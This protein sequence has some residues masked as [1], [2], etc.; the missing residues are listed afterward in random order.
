MN[1][2]TN[3]R[4]LVW[5][6]PDDFMDTDFNPALFQLLLQT[7]NI[8]WIIILPESKSRYAEADFADLNKLE[9]MEIKFLYSSYRQRDPRRLVFYSILYKEINRGKYDLLYFSYG[10]SEPYAIPLFRILNRNKT[11]FAV[12]E[13]NVNDNFRLPMMSNIILNATYPF[14]KYV[15]MFSPSSAAIFGRKYSKAKIFIIP[16]GLK[17]FGAGKIQKT[18][19]EIVFLSFG[20]IN[21]AKNI[22]LLI[23][24]ACNVYDKGFRGF[25]VSINGSCGNW[26][27]YKSK[28]RYPK[29][30]SCDIRKIENTEIADLFSGSH[31]L[32]QPY[33]ST[34]QSGVLKIALNYNVPIIASDLPGFKDEIE[35]GVN[36]FLFATGD[37][38][39][40]E[41][42]LIQ[43]IQSH[44]E[45]YRSL[46]EKM[47]QH[48]AHR[49]SAG[50]LNA[51][52]LDLF[53]KVED[54]EKQKQP[55]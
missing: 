6:T 4:K 23:D 34:S 22:D 24:A 13:G 10:P 29:I 52:Y 36:G 14:V 7:Y 41:R 28:M 19:G 17:S 5:V 21:H 45:K 25:K 53:R 31:Y 15:H 50:I 27:F 40:L 9:G 39:D 33:R 8:K 37:V 30:F 32:V 11:I 20:I 51:Q 43:V 3:K 47:K 1:R 44:Q 18:N 49:Y 48:T 38:L 2:E 42:V 35:E 54:M 26:E 55:R 12:H 46:V 16:F